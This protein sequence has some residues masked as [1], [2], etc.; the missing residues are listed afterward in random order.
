LKS[1]PNLMDSLKNDAFKSRPFA[2][3]R[4]LLASVYLGVAC[5]V[6]VKAGLRPFPLGFSS[7]LVWVQVVLLSLFLTAIP[8][9]ISTPIFFRR[10]VRMSAA[11]GVVLFLI[12]VFGVPFSSEQPFPA[13]PTAQAM[14]ADFHCFVFGLMVGLLAS[15]LGGIAYLRAGPFPSLG[16]R[17]AL[18]FA[19][20]ATG[21]FSL[22]LACPNDSPMHLLNG[23]LGQSVLLVILNALVA[24]LVFA[25]RSRLLWPLGGLTKK[26]NNRK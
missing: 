7:Y 18:S 4:V 9:L 22:Q 8:F 5:A 23:H 16:E 13:W 26:T 12:A 20:S 3:W 21:L 19:G 15:V 24:E 11:L 25:N 10:R 17:F 6:V 2:P 14:K 1:P